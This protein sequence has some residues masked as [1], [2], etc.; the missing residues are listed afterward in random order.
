MLL[1]VFRP[2]NLLINTYGFGIDYKNIYLKGCNSFLFMLKCTQHQKTNK[3]SFKRSSDLSGS[4]EN[5]RSVQAM[6]GRF[7]EIR[8]LF[9]R[10]TATLSEVKV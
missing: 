8:K 10:G 3:K 1:L 9:L 6:Q 2:A 7:N 5:W 4:S